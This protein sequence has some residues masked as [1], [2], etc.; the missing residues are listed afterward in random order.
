MKPKCYNQID[1]NKQTKKQRGPST[2]SDYAFRRGLKLDISHSIHKNEY[3]GLQ[4]Y[5]LLYTIL[6]SEINLT[7]AVNN[8][9]IQWVY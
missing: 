1:K 6:S 8:A 5:N 2:S 3:V 7:K 9:F 4:F